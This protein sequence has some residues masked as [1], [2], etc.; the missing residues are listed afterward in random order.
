MPVAINNPKNV[1]DR[2]SWSPKYFL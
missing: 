1:D 2:I